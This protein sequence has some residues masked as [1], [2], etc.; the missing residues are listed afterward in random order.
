VVVAAEVSDRAMT[1][2]NLVALV[3]GAAGVFQLKS[4]HLGPAARM[5]IFLRASSC[6]IQSQSAADASNI[7]IHYFI[8]N[9]KHYKS[10]SLTSDAAR[11]LSSFRSMQ[12]HTNI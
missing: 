12:V 6:K 10:S 11:T 1:R 8:I 7:E 2:A 5:T 4:L 9:I 3:V